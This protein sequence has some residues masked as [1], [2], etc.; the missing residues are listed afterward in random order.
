MKRLLALALSAALSMS[1]VS[2]TDSTGPA[3]GL[4]GTY[5][6][7]TIN[8]QSLPVQ[9]S[10]NLSTATDVLA[11]QIVVDASGNYSDVITFRDR[12]SNGAPSST[13]QD[14]VTGY[15][16]LSG[17]QVTFTPLD[18]TVQVSTAT[19]SGNTLTFVVPISANTAATF[20]YTR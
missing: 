4:V 19:V 10:A 5:N 18:P 14:N 15:W 8:G 20:V 12:Y 7:Q 2:C 9:I 13:Y 11:E 1:V 6:L 17:N 16:T 3:G